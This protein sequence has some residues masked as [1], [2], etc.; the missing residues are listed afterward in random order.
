M[1]LLI[2]NNTKGAE[3]APFLLKKKG[4][5]LSLCRNKWIFLIELKYASKG[6]EMILA[7]YDQEYGKEQSL[8]DHSL[9]TGELAKKVGDM[10]RLGSTCQVVGILHDIG[11]ADENFQNKLIN[12]S[13]KKVIHS[14]AGLKYLMQFR[15]QSKNPL[16]QE[17]I[18]ILAYAIG[19]HHGVFDIPAQDDDYSWTTRLRVKEKYNT[20]IYHYERDVLSFVENVEKKIEEAYGSG[21]KELIEVGYQE[22]QDS[23]KKLKPVD[24]KEENFYTGLYARLILSILKSADV[25][26]TI[27][28][29]EDVVKPLSSEDYDEYREKYKQRIEEIY[30]SYGKPLNEMNRIRSLAG[31]RGKERGTLDTPG[32][33]RLDL[34]TGAGKT[35]ISLRYGIFQFKELKRSRI[36]YITPF[37]S[38]L[39]QN[40]QVIR[41]IVQEGF[42]E[43]HSNIV[44]NEEESNLKKDANEVLEDM[45]YAFKEY[46]KETWDTPMVA[47]TMVQFAN[48]LFKHRSSNLRRF[49]SLIGSVI[50]LDEVQSLPIKCTH[51]FNSTMNFMAEIMNCTIV[52]C[53]ATQPNYDSQKIKYPIHYGGNNPPDIVKLSDSERNVFERTEIFLM[54]GGDEVTLEDIDQ[55]ISKHPSQSFLV[56]LNTKKSVGEL[57]E[58]CLQHEN[59]DVYYLTTNLCAAHRKDIIEEIKSKLLQN[60]PVVCISTQLIEAGVDLDFNRLI[61]SYAGI[62]SIIQAVGRCNREGKLPGK[63]IVMLANLNKHIENLK[64]LPEINDKKKITWDIL[65]KVQDDARIDLKSLSE[66]FFMRYFANNKN[67]MGFWADSE[68]EKVQ[69][70]DLLSL[71]EE[72]ELDVVH[73]LRQS[74]ETA[75][76]LF[77]LIKDDSKGVIVYYKES[78]ELIGKLEK[79]IDKY[80]EKYE[81][82]YLVE[83]KQIVRKLQPYT[84]NTYNIKKLSNNISFLLDRKIAVLFEGNYDEKVGLTIEEDTDAFLL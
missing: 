79:A 80:Y 72:Y 78:R 65:R 49:T 43:H 61:R 4:M 58:R 2:W 52:H 75:G 20:K 11:K 15:N 33:Y 8:M 16:F 50:I 9:S 7:H 63:G 44:G 47:T 10:V 42:L 1:R 19:A 48:T 38:V 56:V 41:E 40:A 29:Y 84:V 22:Y 66:E 18:E 45:D 55:E 82:Q 69:L 12:N 25:M 57:Y 6:G 36:F 35:Q 60:I 24:R 83:I 32:I 37:L 64:M 31:N 5:I 54:N 3:K 68:D 67:E 81:K 13:S 23:R 30:A 71:N 59:R 77:E 27:N 26:D 70:Y 73:S 39:E 62:D 51:L 46:L 21:I 17:Y 53:T 14:S 76:K 74:F 34:P 28:A